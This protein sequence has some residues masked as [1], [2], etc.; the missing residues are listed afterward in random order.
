MA[1]A[2]ISL[3]GVLMDFLTPILPKIDGEPKREGLIDIH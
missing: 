2:T 3:K 1:G